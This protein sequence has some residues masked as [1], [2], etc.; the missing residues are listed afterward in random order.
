MKLRHENPFSDIAR[1]LAHAPD[2]LMEGS[3]FEGPKAALL[4]L[5]LFVPAKP[6]DHVKCPVCDASV[7]VRGRWRHC[8]ECN[9]PIDASGF[10]LREFKFS[11]AGMAGLLQHELGLTHRKDNGSYYCFQSKRGSLYYVPR[12]ADVE[13]SSLLGRRNPVIV[14]GSAWPK[15]SESG[16]VEVCAIDEVF[17]LGDDGELEVSDNILYVTE[18]RKRALVEV[19]GGNEALEARR[20]TLAKLVFAAVRRLARSGRD[21]RTE[22]GARFWCRKFLELVKRKDGACGVGWETIRN[23][24]Y[25]LCRE[26]PDFDE[27]F[28]DCWE[29]LLSGKA[30]DLARALNKL[31][32]KAE[33]ARSAGVD[34]RSLM[35]SF[36]KFG[37]DGHYADDEVDPDSPDPHDI[38]DPFFEKIYEDVDGK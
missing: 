4:D 1:A 35:A 17:D 20:A 22:G 19:R 15:P 2:P 14:Y 28:R 31:R 34:P 12:E 3:W 8:P 21:A 33:S 7:R 6:A 36:V 16:D 23:D 25:A 26:G 5:G 9:A 32:R 13:R 37:P 11:N 18:R 29:A 30:K 38:N 27:D 24:A 10:D